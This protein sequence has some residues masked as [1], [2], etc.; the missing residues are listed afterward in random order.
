GTP[1][2][3]IAPG[4]LT[5]RIGDQGVYYVNVSVSSG[6]HVVTSHPDY[7][8]S[9]IISGNNGNPGRDAYAWPL[10]YWLQSIPADANAPYVVST[11]PTPKGIVSIVVSDKSDQYFSGVD[12]V[13]VSSSSPGWRLIE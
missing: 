12:S 9:G 3:T 5:Q 6:A 10:P 8:F 1:I 11:A 7:P 13:Q 4:I 2:Y